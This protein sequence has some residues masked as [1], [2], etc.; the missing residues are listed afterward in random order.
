MEASPDFARQL[1]TLSSFLRDEPLRGRIA[2]LENALSGCDADA[3][4]DV[5][6]AHGMSTELLRS[7]VAARDTFGKVSDL[8]HASAIALALPA[9]LAP[10]ERVVLS[11]L[12]AGNTP[13]R[14]F[15]LET[16]ARVAEFKLA[17]LDGGD[18]ARQQ[19]A[20]KDLVRLAGDQSGRA[21]ELYL[22]GSRPISWLR[23]TRSSVR[24]QLRRYAAE[25][26]VFEDMFGDAGIEVGAFTASAAA[27]VRLLDIEQHIP[28]VFGAEGW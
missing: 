22:R 21:P 23:T 5:V 3:V 12:A 20:V 16:D 2:A 11:S 17:R 18:G 7:A 9:I 25:L 4:P 10:G 6:A 13:S 1:A 15:D 24:R 26:A 19:S 14:V 27:H 8:I 28:A